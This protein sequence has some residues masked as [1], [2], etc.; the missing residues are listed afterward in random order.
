[1]TSTIPPIVST[2][3]AAAISRGTLEGSTV[4]RGQARAVTEIEQLIDGQ[5][6]RHERER[7][8]R[9]REERALVCLRETGVRG[10]DPLILREDIESFAR[11]TTAGVA[12]LTLHAWKRLRNT[13]PGPW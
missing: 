5:P 6:T 2:T 11:A 10:L 13:G 3:N 4:P 1:M 9:P 7:G 12:G 8:P